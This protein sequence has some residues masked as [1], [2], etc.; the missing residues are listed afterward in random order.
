M[1]NAATQ[2]KPPL[3]FGRALLLH[4][5]RCG[6]S[7]ILRNWFN[8]KE[9]CPTCGLVFS[10]GESGDYW[11]GGYTINFL[12]AEFSAVIL[13]V[14]LVLATLPN[15]PWNIVGFIALAAATLL[16]V[17]FFPF[18]RTLWLALDLSARPTLRGDSRRRQT[19]S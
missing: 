3:M 9:Q 17:L 13:T 6:G 19:F 16:P 4:C 14:V 12:V 2:R 7:G 10:R 1:N 18:S 15:V 8:L 11:L 5:P